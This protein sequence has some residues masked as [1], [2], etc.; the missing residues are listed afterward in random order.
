MAKTNKMKSETYRKL[1]QAIV[2]STRVPANTIIDVYRNL[3][4]QINS[5]SFDKADIDTIELFKKGLDESIKNRVLERDYCAIM[6]DISAF[7]SLLA[8]YLGFIFLKIFMREKSAYGSEA[9]KLLYTA[10]EKSEYIIDDLYGIRFITMDRTDAIHKTCVYVLNFLNIL[11]NRSKLEKDDF[12]KF[13]KERYDETTIQSI[14]RLFEIGLNP[15]EISRTDSVEKFNINNFEVGK[16]D[17]PTEADR[18]L[19]KKFAG[20]MKFYF[21]PKENGYQSI[22]IVLEISSNS[23]VLPG[24]KI[25]L[26]FRTD[27]MNYFSNNEIPDNHKDRVAAYRPYFYLSDED[28]KKAQI[29]G[30]HY[31]L[32]KEDNDSS[33]MFFPK[34]FAFDEFCQVKANASKYNKK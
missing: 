1:Q 3:I 34:K 20:K 5:T 19:L 2:A 11:C 17:L 4:Y 15:K 9:P 10:V 13:V 8:E 32:N 14:K 18:E 28:L 26:Q 7:S 30:L 29:A 24:G 33:G 16:I 27:K 6:R 25:E 31:P 23:A 22:H 12:M 21:D